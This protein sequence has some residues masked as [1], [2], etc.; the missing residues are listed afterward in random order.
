MHALAD[1]TLLS[2]LKRSRGSS[3]I[4]FYREYFEQYTIMYN[5]CNIICTSE[6]GLFVDW[7][8]KPRDFVVSLDVPRSRRTFF[9]VLKLRTCREQSRCWQLQ[10]ELFVNF[11]R[12]HSQTYLY[13]REIRNN[14]CAETRKCEKM[15]RE[16]IYCREI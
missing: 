9:C 14:C 1:L 2:S 8:R 16:R 12:V 5:F 7:H 4:F 13:R 15:I 11:P 3:F 6:S 10:R